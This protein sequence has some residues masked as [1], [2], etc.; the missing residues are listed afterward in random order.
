V[1]RGGLAYLIEWSVAAD[2]ADGRLVRVLEDWTPTFPGLCLYYPGRRHLPAGLRAL[3][4]LVQ[5]LRRV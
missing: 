5:E 2:L 3:V 1:G 4:D